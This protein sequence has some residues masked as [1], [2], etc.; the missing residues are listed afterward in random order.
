MNTYIKCT[1]LATQFTWEQIQQRHAMPWHESKRRMF[2]WNSLSAIEPM[3]P[4]NVTNRT[5]EN[6][7][8][9]QE[10]IEW[11]L[12]CGEIYLRI[13]S[14]Y[15]SPVWWSRFYQLPILPRCMWNREQRTSSL[16]HAIWILRQPSWT[17][18]RWTVR[19]QH[20]GWSIAMSVERSCRWFS[21][22]FGSNR[23]HWP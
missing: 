15:R 19:S 12:H 18:S 14:S 17:A 4:I 11:P 21:H 7:M 2:R 20:L 8:Y 3:D 9:V 1:I 22:S 5:N 23:W 16:W 13:A 6:V 10:R